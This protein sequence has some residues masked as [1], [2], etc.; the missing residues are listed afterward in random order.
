MSLSTFSRFNAMLLACSIGLLA[1]GAGAL[2]ALDHA[3]R[4]P[5]PPITATNCIDEKFK[6][7]HD[8]SLEGRNLI[9]VGSSVTWR[10]L[11]FSAIEPRWRHLRPVNAAPCYLQIHQTAYLTR[12]YLDNMQSVR[13]VLSVISMQDFQNCRDDGHFFDTDISRSYIFDH[14]SPMYIYFTNFRPMPFLKDVLK[15]REMRDGTR[16]REPLVMDRY[17]S[18]PYTLRPPEIRND[19]HVTPECIT[20][21]RK[22]ASELKER[23][24]IWAV[25]LLPPMPAWLKAYDPDGARDLAWRRE[26]TEHL[27]GTGA[28]VLDGREGPAFRD[29]DF[30]DPDHL[31][32]SSVPAF[33]RWVFRR[34]DQG[35]GP[36]AAL[37]RS[38]NAL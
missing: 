37:G 13:M 28:I 22:L 36:A 11:D 15:I 34:L 1:V 25:V 3:D 17:G 29:A 35:G 23:G 4:L 27:Q 9:A 31:H 8:T 5:P 26:T 6:F 18:G 10:N 30:T 38:A 24:V 32:W 33:T 2:L 7:L 21:V 12:F 20:Q 19:R 14:E 16:E